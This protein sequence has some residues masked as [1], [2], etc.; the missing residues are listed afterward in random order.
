MKASYIWTILVITLLCVNSIM[1]VVLWKERRLGA[2]AAHERAG[3]KDFLVKELSL[4]PKQ[5]AQFDS[6][7]DQHRAIVDSLDENIRTLRDRLFGGLSRPADAAITNDILQQ[8][9]TNLALIDKAT[10]YHFKKLRELLNSSQR[11]KFDNTIKQVLH[12]MARQGPPNGPAGPP[13]RNGRPDGPPDG[14]PP[15]EK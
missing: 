3:V 12:I 5:A 1:L 15:P 11:Q 4:T 14:P 13:P 9:G 7:R 6:L 10:F 8:I 2:P